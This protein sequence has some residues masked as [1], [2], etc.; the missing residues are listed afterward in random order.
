[1]DVAVTIV[2]PETRPVEDLEP[3]SAVALRRF[4][5]AHSTVPDLPLAIQL[6]SFS[7]VVLRGD[8]DV[9]LG[10][11]RAVTVHLATFHSPDDVIVAVV[12]APDRVADW[13]W[14]KWLPHAQDERRVDAAGASRLVFESMA[15]VEAHLG[16][17]LSDRP[18]HSPDARPLTTAAHVL[19]IVDGGEVAPTCQLQGQGLLGT[20]V[21][22]TSGMVPRDAGRWRPAARRPASSGARRPCGPPPSTAARGARR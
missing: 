5:R 6:R 11:A 22:D 13:D 1:M 18:R 20:T 17:G 21:L 10:L 7:R 9:V 8:R 12:A 16:D 4:V 19:V 15:A 14:V 3:M 2:P